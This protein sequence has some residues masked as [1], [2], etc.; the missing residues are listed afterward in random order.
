MSTRGCEETYSKLAHSVLPEW[1]SN[2][3][4]LG[5]KE[6]LE[7]QRE[8]PVRTQ[9]S[10]CLVHHSIDISYIMCRSEKFGNTKL[11]SQVAAH[12]E[13]QPYAVPQVTG[14]GYRS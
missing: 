9:M 13:A 1:A 6:T 14:Y 8:P 3:A 4:A 2:D 5:T 12:V 11:T 10:I 7:K